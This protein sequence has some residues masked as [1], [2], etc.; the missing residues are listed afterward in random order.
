MIYAVMP[1]EDY[2]HACDVLR[3]YTGEDELIKSGELPENIDK[4]YDAGSAAGEE[5]GY[6]IGY[7]ASQFI[8]NQF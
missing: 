7:S 2:E 5:K 6:S 4:V 8:Y 3:E 1:K